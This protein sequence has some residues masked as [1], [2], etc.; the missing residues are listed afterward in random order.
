MLLALFLVPLASL[1][2]GI[3]NHIDKHLISKISKN[4]DYKGLLIFSS[5]VA[6]ML[7]FPISLIICKFKISVDI[8]FLLIIFLASISYLFGTL[9]YFK[10]LKKNDASLVT[11]MFQLIPV[12]GYFLGL[13]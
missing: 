7:L 11:A 13:T 6:G 5:L 9:F 12:F 10:T 4:G 2:W 8:K 3:T 1:L